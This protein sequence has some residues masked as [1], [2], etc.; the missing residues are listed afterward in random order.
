MNDLHKQVL[1]DLFFIHQKCRRPVRTC[2]NFATYIIKFT[3]VPT[4]NYDIASIGHALT[5]MACVAH[6]RINIH[7]CVCVCMCIC[8]LH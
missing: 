7:M 1:N 5:E 2:A 4:L 3:R 6:G 8:V